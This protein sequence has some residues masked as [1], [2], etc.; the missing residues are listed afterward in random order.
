MKWSLDG[1]ACIIIIIGGLALKFSGIDGEVWSLVICAFGWL[2]KG[3]Y[4]IRKAAKGG[5]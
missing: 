2:C 4:D 1:I 5:K 3:Q